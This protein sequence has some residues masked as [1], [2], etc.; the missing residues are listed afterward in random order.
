MLCLRFEVMGGGRNVR[1][2]EH[3]QRE[4]GGGGGGKKKHWRA[5]RPVVGHAFRCR[6]IDREELAFLSDAAV[7]HKYEIRVRVKGYEYTTT[8]TTLFFGGR[9]GAGAGVGR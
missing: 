8:A 4:R 1:R 5:S 3:E 7:Y 9:P 6:E 2:R